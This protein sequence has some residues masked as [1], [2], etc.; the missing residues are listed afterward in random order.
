MNLLD[1]IKARRA[2]LNPDGETYLP[3]RGCDSLTA[4]EEQLARDHE[5]ERAEEA[6]KHIQDEER[7][8]AW[9]CQRLQEAR[10]TREIYS[11]TMQYSTLLEQCE[12]CLELRKLIEDAGGVVP[13][14][15]HQ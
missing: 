11:N 7:A 2:E 4:K 5:L 12:R 1:R 10:R 8:M 9:L 6:L 14:Q 15:V 3:P 13:P